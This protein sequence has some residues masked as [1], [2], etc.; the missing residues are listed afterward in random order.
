MT[1]FNHSFRSSRHGATTLDR[2]TL[3]ITTFSIIKLSRMRLFATHSITV[4]CAMTQYAECRVFIDILS[5]I[6][7]SVIMLSVML[8]AIMLSVIML[9]VIMLSVVAP[10]TINSQ[11]YITF[12]VKM[13]SSK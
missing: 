1:S 2:M 5:V 4:L 9:N 7:L 10:P 8:N 6:M 13:A 12:F 11:Y 3:T